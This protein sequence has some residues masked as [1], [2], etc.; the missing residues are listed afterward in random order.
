[1]N[2]GIIGLGLMGASIAKTIKKRNLGVVYGLDNQEVL[3]KAFLLDAI[4]DKIDD[5]NIS[6][7][8]I[9]FICVYPREIP[10]FIKEYSPKL[11]NDAIICDI[12]GNK[13]QI[14]KVMEQ[15]SNEYPN[16]NYIATHPM[17]GRE[18]TG[19]SHSV[20]TLYDKSSFILIPVKYNISALANF[21]DF[22]KLLG[23]T[24]FIYTTAEHHDEMIAYTSQL[25][26]IVSSAFVKNAKA[27]EHFG[28]SAGSFKD[29]TRVAKLNAKMW[30]ENLIDNRDYLIKDIDLI[31]QELLK[32]KQVLQDNDEQGLKDLLQIGTDIKESLKD[33]NQ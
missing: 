1:M 26:H 6:C 29:L 32:Y 15:V 24:T 4:D 27:K 31:V 3:D 33:K 5:S 21:V 23:A 16:L 18:F 28:Y 30:S 17:A 9:L 13:R 12:G 25:C 7:I 14:V 2:I 11:K 22:I 10:K 20:T 19:I 8:D